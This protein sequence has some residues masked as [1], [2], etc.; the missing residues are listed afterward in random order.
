[1]SSSPPLQSIQTQSTSCT[2]TAND[3]FPLSVGMSDS[4]HFRGGEEG[5]Y[6][7]ETVPTTPLLNEQ[8]TQKQHYQYVK[9][10][11]EYEE[12]SN[13][14]SN[15]A[16]QTSQTPSRHGEGGEGE[17]TRLTPQTDTRATLTNNARF[18]TNQ[19]P[20]PNN[21]SQ[22]A[23]QQQQQ[24]Y[25]HS[26]PHTY[27]NENEQQ[28]QQQQQQDRN[29]DDSNNR[30]P[31]SVSGVEIVSD[32]VSVITELT[33]SVALDPTHPTT[34]PQ[35]ETEQL[36]IYQQ[37]S[38]SQEK[39]PS[40]EES[41]HTPIRTNTQIN[42]SSQS[43]QQQHPILHSAVPTTPLHPITPNPLQSSA[44]G[45]TSN[46]ATIQ[47]TP[48]LMNNTPTR[49]SITTTDELHK[50]YEQR[51]ANITQTH[52]NEIDSILT[53]LNTLEGSYNDKLEYLRSQLTKKEIMMDALTNSLKELKSKSKQDILSLQEY[54]QENE[55]IGN[56]LKHHQETI[57]PKMQKT[58]DRLTAKLKE[59]ERLE[60][61]KR[62]EA[63]AEAQEDIRKAAEEQFAQAQKTYWELNENYEKMR[64][65]RDLHQSEFQ[66]LRKNSEGVE[67]KNKAQVTA[68]MAELAEA[69]AGYATVQAECMKLKQ[70]YGEKMQ[71]L[72]DRENELEER[73]GNVEREC[74][75]A[76]QLV[77]RVV[78]EKEELKNENNDL[79]A[80]C[81]ELM[82]IM[83]ANES[84]GA[85]GSSSAG[86]GGGGV[87][88][89]GG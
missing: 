27:Q 79:Q 33:Q 58:I 19:S 35:S 56:Q 83:E 66:H 11:E 85:C 72:V 37:H 75:E 36:S 86:C 81:E 73:L 89:A 47:S 80:L 44:A 9:L 39:A 3:G 51:I 14:N 65:E 23:G 41:H 69:R 48:A 25:T 13:R 88:G 21:L 68:L 87:T 32:A 34:P 12:M 67:R 76:H 29:H 38:H 60:E 28:R 22:D 57:I 50:F 26:S 1:M 64:E 63:V 8:Q 18:N 2:S 52:S 54:E 45:A 43:S 42:P 30:S 71:T 24:P 49:N 61:I 46:N 16:K 62:K 40:I 53:E 4:Q 74:K 20:Y 78:R 59:G 5:P 6:N 77:G 84:N 17:A 15:D 31:I 70:S 7:E 10:V 55:M 82:G